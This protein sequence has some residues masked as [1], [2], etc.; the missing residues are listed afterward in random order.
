MSVWGPS[1][2]RADDQPGFTAVVNAANPVTSLSVEEVSRLLLKKVTR[3]PDGLEVVPVDQS[4]DSSVRQAFSRLIHG[5]TLRAVDAF[6]KQ[7]IF[8]GRAIPPLVVATD[9][10][11][12]NY[13][14]GIPGAIGYVTGGTPLSK[15]VRA[16]HILGSSP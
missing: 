13:V 5:R 9:E 2:L 1:D 4:S 14:E 12:V 16:L 6:W 10:D 11:V 3:W 15:N 8:S 7:C